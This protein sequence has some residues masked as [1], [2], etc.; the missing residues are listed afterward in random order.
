MRPPKIIARREMS[1]H[2]LGCRHPRC[3]VRCGL[4]GADVTQRAITAPLPALEKAV[5]AVLIANQ[6]QVRKPPTQRQ[7]APTLSCR[8]CAAHRSTWVRRLRSSYSR[9]RSARVTTLRRDSA[10]SRPMA[11]KLSMSSSSLCVAGVQHWTTPKSCIVCEGAARLAVAHEMA[12]Q[13]GSSAGFYNPRMRLNRELCLSELK[14]AL[15]A[16][17]VPRAAAAAAARAWVP[18]ATLCGSLQ[19]LTRSVVGRDRHGG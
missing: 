18:R 19:G 5:W 14:A 16:R 2:P 15:R 6:T 4:A 9:T 8:M 7:S 13:P 10:P 11:G 17:G 3:P 1:E 12:A